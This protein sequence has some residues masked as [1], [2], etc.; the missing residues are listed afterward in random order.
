MAMRKLLV[1]TPSPER[2]ASAARS[3]RRDRRRRVRCLLCVAVCATG[4]RTPRI[5]R[6]ARRIR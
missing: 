6:S 4:C 5:G 2:A 3:D 1:L